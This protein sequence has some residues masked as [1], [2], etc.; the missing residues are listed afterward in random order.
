MV[1]ASHLFPMQKPLAQSVGRV[2]ALPKKSP[3]TLVAVQTVLVQS[4]P[5]VQPFAGAHA[6]QLAPPQSA[7]VSPISLPFFTPSVHEGFAHS[8]FV[9]TALRQSSSL[10]HARKLAHGPQA[11]PPQSLS[12]SSPFAIPS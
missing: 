2:H 9:Q 6:G 3:Q 8:L 1:C 7:S 4:V 10:L 12:V 5:V 11:A